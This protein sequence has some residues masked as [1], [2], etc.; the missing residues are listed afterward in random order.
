MSRSIS[1]EWVYAIVV[2][3]LTSSY[4]IWGARLTEELK[5]S[6]KSSNTEISDYIK[7]TCFTKSICKKYGEARQSCAGAGDV[8]SCINIR[9][10][11]NSHDYCDV[12][13]K[14][15]NPNHIAL[16]NTSQCVASG[17]LDWAESLKS[18]GKK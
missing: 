18:A 8:K 16:P 4:F 10:D 12:N 2:L 17:I 13:G 6:A 3:V 15:L 9:T 11:G 7:I 1:D 14:M 5:D